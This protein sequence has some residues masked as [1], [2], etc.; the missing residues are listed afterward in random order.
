MLKRAHLPFSMGNNNVKKQ[1]ENSRIHLVLSIVI[2]LI[3]NKLWD[4]RIYWGYIYMYSHF[5]SG[6]KLLAHL[7]RVSMRQKYANKIPTLWDYK[8]LSFCYPGFEIDPSNLDNFRKKSDL[9]AFYD[10]QSGE[11]AELYVPWG[12]EWHNYAKYDLCAMT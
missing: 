3:I 4:N 12:V 1:Q 2:R 10:R 6:K 8:S 5:L 7:R 11:F 9:S